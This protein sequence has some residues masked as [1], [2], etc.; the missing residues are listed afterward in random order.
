MSQASFSGLPDEVIQSI[1]CYSPPQAAAALE[2]TSRRFRDVTSEPL[3]WRFYC[4]TSYQYWDNS[5]DI[6]RKLI[7]PPTDADWKQ[8]Y[9][10][11]HLTDITTTQLLDSILASQTGR[12]RKFERIARFGYDAKDTLLRNLRPGIDDEYELSRGYESN[13]SVIAAKGM[14]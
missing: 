13:L 14:Y 9:I 5:H 1:L 4:R 6:S 11:R 2:Q 8:L 10:Q 7:S 3:L 12:T